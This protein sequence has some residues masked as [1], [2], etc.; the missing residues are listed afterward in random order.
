MTKDGEVMVIKNGLQ[1]EKIKEIEAVCNNTKIESKKNS[2]EIKTIKGDIKT[3]KGEMRAM[4][5]KFSSEFLK[6][7]DAFQ[8]DISDQSERIERYIK[9]SKDLTGKS[10]DVLDKFGD[11]PNVIDA[12]FE[13][14]KKSI[15]KTLKEGENERKKIK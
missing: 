9:A 7:Q 2:D 6:L 3:I 13:D 11:I 4:G 14:M 10:I 15:I 12:R 8:K 1:D 5:D